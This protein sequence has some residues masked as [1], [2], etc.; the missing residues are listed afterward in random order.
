MG[1]DV[2]NIHKLGPSGHTLTIEEKAGLQVAIIQRQ[3]EENFPSKPL[4]WGKVSK[5]INGW[6]IYI[7]HTNV[8]S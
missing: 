7:W 8:L 1:L 5:G 4:F 6:I 2:E 3:K